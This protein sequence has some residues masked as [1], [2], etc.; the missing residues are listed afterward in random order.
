ME[1]PYH[2][3]FTQFPETLYYKTYK[4]YCKTSNLVIVITKQYN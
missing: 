3:S 4:S 1:Q 2:L